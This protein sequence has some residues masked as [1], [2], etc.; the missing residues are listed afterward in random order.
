MDENISRAAG[1][2]HGQLVTPEEMEAAIAAAGRI[3]VQRNTLYEILDSRAQE[4]V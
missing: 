2:A 4:S 1:A 3:P